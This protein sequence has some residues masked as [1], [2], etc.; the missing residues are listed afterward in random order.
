MSKPL[1]HYCG[2]SADEPVFK[3]IEERIEIMSREQKLELALAALSLRIELGSNYPF[4]KDELQNFQLINK[5][6]K[7]GKVELVQALITQARER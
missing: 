7:E 2:A 4:T 1:L 3:Q 6:S 5:L